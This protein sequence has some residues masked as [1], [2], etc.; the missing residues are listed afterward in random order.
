MYAK[1]KFML[2]SKVH[3]GVTARQLT[4][5]YTGAE[6]A[7]VDDFALR[8]FLC[9]GAIAWHRHVDEDEL[10]LVYTGVMTLDSE[11]G[12]V[13]LRPGELTVV[14]K[15]VR[16]RSASLV[17]AEVL[18]FQ[19]R[20]LADQQNGHRRLYA[21]NEEGHL[22]KINIYTEAINIPTP[23]LPHLLAEVG[24][25]AVKLIVCDGISPQKAGLKWTSLLLV[26][27]GEVTV[28]TELG[29]VQLYVGDAQVIPRGVGFFISGQKRSLLLEFSREVT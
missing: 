9:Q 29:E 25:F 23:F 28:H 11:I 16:H 19:S 21:L 18:I 1:D 3:V 17:R 27:Q 4:E 7:N 22:S 14:P 26:Q 5:P 24:D 13:F 8:V 15:G 2:P 20:M 12:P 6:I 10:F